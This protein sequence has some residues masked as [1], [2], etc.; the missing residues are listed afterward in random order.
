MVLTKLN[1]ILPKAQVTPLKALVTTQSTV[2]TT[3]GLE[4]DTSIKDTDSQLVIMG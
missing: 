4:E 2:A 1:S 3:L